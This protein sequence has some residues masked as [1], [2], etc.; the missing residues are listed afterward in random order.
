MDFC[1]LGVLIAGAAL[2][3]EWRRLHAVKSHLR[4]P[5][6]PLFVMP[7]HLRGISAGALMSTEIVGDVEDEARSVSRISTITLIGRMYLILYIVS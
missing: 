5:H 7:W 3:A 1:G 6:E 4:L 2:D